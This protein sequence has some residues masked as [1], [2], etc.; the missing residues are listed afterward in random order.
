MKQTVLALTLTVIVPAAA[1]AQELPVIQAEYLARTILD[2]EVA[3]QEGGT[4]LFTADGR[5][6]LE[7]VV[8]GERTA[9]LIFPDAAEQVNIN[10]N[11]GVVHRGPVGLPL[12]RL[13]QPVF[14]NP[15]PHRDSSAAETVMTPI[16]EQARG[17]LLLHGFRM[18]G[19]GRTHE[20]WFYVVT[21]SGGK[22]R[23]IELESVLRQTLHDGR[24]VVIEKRLVEATRVA[25]DARMFGIPEGLTVKSFHQR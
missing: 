9:E 22:T 16:G 15:M 6:R 12:P 18:E 13:E 14:T 17:P 10:Y 4:Y 21:T 3:E 7:R 20:I 5:Q 25:A 19:V 24:E 1:L 23:A 11:L 8:N 2:G